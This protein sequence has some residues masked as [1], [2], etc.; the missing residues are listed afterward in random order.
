MRALELDWKTR[1]TASQLY[2]VLPKLEAVMQ[3]LHILGKTK[4]LDRVD[5]PREPDAPEAVCLTDSKVF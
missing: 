4:L 5:E 2:K 1:I 3:D